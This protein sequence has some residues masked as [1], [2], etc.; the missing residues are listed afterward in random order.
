MVIIFLVKI[1]EFP[2]EQVNESTCIQSATE[3]A[4]K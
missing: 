2:V 4:G 1:I 3:T